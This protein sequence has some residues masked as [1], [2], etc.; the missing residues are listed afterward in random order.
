MT[1]RTA[2]QYS[3][4]FILAGCSAAA[5][6]TGVAFGFEA[7]HLLV[8]NAA[9][10]PVHLTLKSTGAASTDDPE[11]VAG[12]TLDLRGVI[13]SGLNL[14]TTSTTTSTGADGHRVTVAAWGGW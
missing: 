12:T 7:T 14:T 1:L 8:R 11:L 10:V 4:E 5:A 13:V 6:A 2:N 9:G 3:T